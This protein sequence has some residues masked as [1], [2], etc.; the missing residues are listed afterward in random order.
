MK[1]VHVNEIYRTESGVRRALESDKK[2][3]DSLQSFMHLA[4]DAE[5]RK[6]AGSASFVTSQLTHLS[7]ESCI[8]GK[9]ITSSPLFIVNIQNWSTVNVCAQV[10]PQPKHL[11]IY[12]IK[13]ARFAAGT[14]AVKKKKKRKKKE[15]KKRPHCAPL[16]RWPQSTVSEWTAGPKIYKQQPAVSVKIPQKVSDAS[17][18]DLRFCRWRIT[19]TYRADSRWHPLTI[20]RDTKALRKALRQLILLS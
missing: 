17:W 14:A 12:R 19:L 8:W 10:P 5:R 1:L 7:Y 11:P 13:I 9:C 18:A 4:A 2:K 6:Q 3:K 15:K 16:K 20:S